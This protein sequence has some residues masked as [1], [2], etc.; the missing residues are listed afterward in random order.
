MTDDEMRVKIAEACG[1]EVISL[2]FSLMVDSGSASKKP[3]VVLPDYV[4]DLNAMHKVEKKL[5][6]DAFFEY[7]RL[8]ESLMGEE[9]FHATA[10]QRAEAFLKTLGSKEEFGI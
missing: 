4:N 7:G 5:A 9:F 10:R 6:L 1:Y 3:I 2:P 8:L